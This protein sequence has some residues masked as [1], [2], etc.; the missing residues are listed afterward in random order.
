MRHKPRLLGAF[1]VFT[2]TLASCCYAQTQSTATTAPIKTE[3][4]PKSDLDA[5][6]TSGEELA[7]AFNKRDAK[8]VAAFWTK[9]CEYIDE[10]GQVYEGRD[11]IESLYTDLFTTSDAKMLIETEAVRSLSD[12]VVLEDGRAVVESA[13]TGVRS[14]NR[15]T[16]VHLKVDGK[17]LLASV[18]ELGSDDSAATTH[19][20]DLEWLIGEW[21][22]E[23]H[24]V[25][26]VSKCRWIVD[27][28]FVERS[29]STTEL[30]GTVTTGL[31]IIGWNAQNNQMQSWNFSADGG[32]A[33]GVWAATNGGWIAKVSGSTGTGVSTT[34]VNVLK[35]L[36]DNA[37]VWQSMDRT[38]GDVRL[39]DTDEVVI[40]RQPTTK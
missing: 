36:D 13:K 25:R 14:V 26:M 9:D 39:P 24:G 1:L 40:R 8:A 20:A 16:A 7:A 12:S 10:S 3:A 30:D 21:V 19:M 27:K 5:I 23:E 38:V 33:I 37:Y 2:A 17:W 4:K 6:R 32:N 28:K 29:Y 31:Q 35:K 22:A 34:A 11:A 15:Y 18:R